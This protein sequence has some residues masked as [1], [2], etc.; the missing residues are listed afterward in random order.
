MSSE[1]AP[2]WVSPSE[3]AAVENEATGQ[4]KPLTGS[5]QRGRFQVGIIKSG[6]RLIWLNPDAT[7]R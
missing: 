3:Q 6:N 5:F 2:D 7:V 1:A 4:S